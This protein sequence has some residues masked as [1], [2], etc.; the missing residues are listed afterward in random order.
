MSKRLSSWIEAFFIW[1]NGQKSTNL[2]TKNLSWDRFLTSEFQLK[3]YFPNRK[4]FKSIISLYQF[5]DR[6]LWLTLP[7][8]K[9]TYESFFPLRK[10]LKPDLLSS[11]TSK[12]KSPKKAVFSS[13]LSPG[14]SSAS[15]RATKAKGCVKKALEEKELTFSFSNVLRSKNKDPWILNLNPEIW[16]YLF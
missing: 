4:N 5:P 7:N 8:K 14:S 16:F 15:L 9:I 2:S 12:R 1:D 13:R 3:F 10:M 6:L 11:R